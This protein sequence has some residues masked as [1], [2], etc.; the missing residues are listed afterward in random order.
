MTVVKTADDRR[1][2]RRLRRGRRAWNLVSRADVRANAR[3]GPPLRKLA[4]EH[5]ES[6]EGGAVLDIGCGVG[7]MLERLRE[8]VGP[9]GRV[10]GVDYSP[11]MVA[12]A[13]KLVRD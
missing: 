2:R 3:L 1:Y 12:A 5:L 4:L 9:S 10:V 13:R 6:R 11:R 7:A 8:A